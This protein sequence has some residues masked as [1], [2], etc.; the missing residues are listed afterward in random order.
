[1][2]DAAQQAAAAG[3]YDAAEGLL[4]DAVATQQVTLGSS[5][6]DLAT[7][8]NNLAF[9]CE[10]TGSLW[11]AVLAHVANNVV[12]TAFA[13]VD[14]PVLFAGVSVLVFAGCAVW[15]VRALPPVPAVPAVSAPV[16]AGPPP[17]AGDPPPV[18]GDP[19]RPA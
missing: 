14:V 2:I 5:H 12:A 11:P 19:E 13:G 16:A 15:L 8:L 9:V 4:R 7:T 10:R 17:V 1:M 3:D 6:P 18:A